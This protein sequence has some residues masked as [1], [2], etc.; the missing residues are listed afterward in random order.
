[1]QQILLVRESPQVQYPLALSR[2]LDCLPNCHLFGHDAA[3]VWN[4]EICVL[5]ADP[6]CQ[7]RGPLKFD[8]PCYCPSQIDTALG[9]WGRECRA[10]EPRRPS[11]RCSVKASL[12]GE[13]RG[14]E[15]RLCLK[16]CQIEPSRTCEHAVVK[17]CLA[18]N[19]H[20][21]KAN[22]HVVRICFARKKLCSIESLPSWC[23]PAP[24]W[25]TPVSRRSGQAA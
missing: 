23:R 15:E 5:K 14:T 25:R 11:K 2:E 4:L 9:T 6:A 10:V 13:L 21:G 1:M 12:A 22:N 3:K 16:P 8:V 17:N 20:T 24:G 18:G 19:T 7:E